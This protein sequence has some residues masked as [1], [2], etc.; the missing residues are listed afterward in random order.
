MSGNV[1]SDAT[2]DR[3]SDE[4]SQSGE[5]EWLSMRNAQTMKFMP[6]HTLTNRPETGEK[7]VK[8]SAGKQF[9]KVFC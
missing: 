5:I 9:R 1:A 4:V 7:E 8:L 2:D 6:R 3:V